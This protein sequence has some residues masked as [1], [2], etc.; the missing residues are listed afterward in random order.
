MANGLAY[1]RAV[2]S[3]IPLGPP[4]AWAMLDNPLY[5]VHEIGHLFGC[6]H[7]IEQPSWGAKYVKNNYNYG[8]Y[9]EGTNM[10]TIMAYP[11][12][13]HDHWI[14]FFSSSS[15]LFN[16][17][18]CSYHCNTVRITDIGLELRELNT[19]Q[20]QI[21]LGSPKHDNRKQIM[22]MRFIVSEYGD[23]SGTCNP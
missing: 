16:G 10:A 1:A 2:D 11:T 8:Y 20:G 22:K 6:H 21:A 13:T 18:D 4:L 23:E 12:E 5:L 3:D 17:K 9:P 7:S 14:P 15:R 19:T